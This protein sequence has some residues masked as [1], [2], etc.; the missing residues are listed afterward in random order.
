MATKSMA[1]TQ[2]EK[3]SA[4]ERAQNHAELLESALARP[5]IREVMKVY[6][7][8][9][10]KDRGLDTYRSATRKPERITTTDSSRA[11]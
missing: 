5:G 1:K 9:P 2:I 3:R 6:G 7:D 11:Q 10:E 8:W 4:S